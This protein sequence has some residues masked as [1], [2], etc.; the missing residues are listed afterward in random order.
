MT[1]LHF[2]DERLQQF[3][4]IVR[5]SPATYKVI[6]DKINN[7]SKEPNLIS[8][9]DIS[10]FIRES[11]PAEQVRSLSA[12]LTFMSRFREATSVDRTS[13]QEAIIL[14]L[15]N[16]KCESEKVEGWRRIASDF[17][18]IVFSDSFHIAIKATDL[19][20]EHDYHIHKMKC[21]VNAR[22]VF[23]KDDVSKI[24][25]YIIWPD[26]HIQ[27]SDASSEQSFTVAL[28]REDVEVMLD[29]AERALEKIDSLE[30]SFRK[31]GI[32]VLVYTEEAVA[33]L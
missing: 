14:G 30:Q 7:A 19:L 21:I 22:P 13:L 5:I 28:S 4:R 6:L 8:A 26:L 18:E 15:N 1:A 17:L 20:F 29:E 10:G 9:S 23:A 12:L 16:A 11:V 25:G 24:E 33:N 31:K 32:K 2:S 3:D 27:I